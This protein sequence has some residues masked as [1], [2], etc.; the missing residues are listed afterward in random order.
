[1]ATPE[2]LR[3]LADQLE[4]QEDL[5]KEYAIAVEDYAEEPDDPAAREQYQELA[6]KVRES[7]R[8]IRES[9][10]MVAPNSPGSVTVGP[11]TVGRRS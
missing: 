6:Q 4:K 11:V 9:G 1:M 10:F 8:A 3:V 2:E 7:R 5:E